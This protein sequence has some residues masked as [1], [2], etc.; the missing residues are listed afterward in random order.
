MASLYDGQYPT[1]SL[2]AASI[3][4]TLSQWIEERTG[5]RMVLPG[6]SAGLVRGQASGGG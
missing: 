4:I 6:V 5:D 3:E 2:Q 1:M